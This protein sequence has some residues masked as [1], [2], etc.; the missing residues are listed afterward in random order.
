MAVPYSALLIADDVSDEAER[1]FGF[2]I[3]EANTL[4]VVESI[5]Q[6]VTGILEGASGLGRNLIVRAYT[7]YFQYR[8]W[9]WDEARDLYYVMAPQWPVV[10]I[11]TS[12][13]T[14]GASSDSF[15]NEADMILNASRFSGVVT[16]YA[17]Y[18]R[19][20]QTL[21]GLQ[22]ESGLSA[23]GTLPSDLPYDLRNVALNAVL[24]NLAARRFGPGQ[25]AV[26]MNPAVQTTTIQEPILDYVS[27][28][29]RERVYHHRKFI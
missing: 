3:T 14:S 16:Y 10:E 20:E 5:I 2:D 29:V 19:P 27:Q 15:Q 4:K 13:F 21:V 8:D 18:K 22:A 25:R 7:H 1:D 17:G 23:M 11:D 26:T 24:N 9:R 28:L 6:E 12:G